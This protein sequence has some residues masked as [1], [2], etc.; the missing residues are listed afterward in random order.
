MLM[1]NTEYFSILENV[2]TQITSAQNKAVMGINREQIILYWEI[3]K[4][5]INNAEWGINLLTIWPEI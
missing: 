5:I 3:G 1:N 4:I 2:K